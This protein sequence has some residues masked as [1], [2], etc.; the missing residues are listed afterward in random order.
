MR[1]T[2]Q[3]DNGIRSFEQRTPVDRLCQIWMPNHFDPGAEWRLRR[4]P[5]GGAKR[6]PVL[7][8]RRDDRP[9][10][11]AG[12]SGDEDSPYIPAH[13]AVHGLPRTGDRIVFIAIAV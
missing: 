7:R 2:S 1:N 6:V 9:A 11:E 4:R 8:K 13:G 3:V 10:D 12:R 5:H